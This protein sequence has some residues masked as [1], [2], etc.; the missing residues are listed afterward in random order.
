MTDF[1]QRATEM[2]QALLAV[3]RLGA[4]EIIHRLAASP[5]IEVVERVVVPAMERIGNGWEAGSVALSQVYMSARICEELVTLLEP[6]PEGFRN[7]QP[8]MAITVLDDYHMLGKRI[9]HSVLRAAGYEVA[10]YGRTVIADLVGRVAEDGIEVLLIST[11]M[12]R[13]AWRLWICGDS[14]RS[15]V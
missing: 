1:L 9:I 12:L 4:E 10:D 15:A 2:E 6:G 13:S 14:C 8:R 7:P 3:D 5:A 11:L